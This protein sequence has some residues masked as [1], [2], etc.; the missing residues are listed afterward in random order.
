MRRGPSAKAASVGVTLTKLAV[1]KALGWLFREQLTE[2]YGIDAHVEIV[3]GEAVSGKLLALQIKS[4]PSW[5]SQ[6]GPGGWWFRP[7]ADHVQYWTNHSLPVAVVLVHPGTERCHW[8][9]SWRMRPTGLCQRRP[10]L[11]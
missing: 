11:S 3:E 10:G 2:D 4:G 5:F 8:Q 9:P 1:E 6:P 7:D